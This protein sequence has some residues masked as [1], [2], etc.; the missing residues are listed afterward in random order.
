MTTPAGGYGD[1]A[2]PPQPDLTTLG[3]G[4][5]AM[6]PDQLHEFGGTVAR[7]GDAIGRM[8]AEL[9]DLQHHGMS[10][11]SGEYAPQ[12][13]QFY[14]NLISREAVPAAGVALGEL[15]KMQREVSGSAD[16][17]EQTDQASASQW[18]A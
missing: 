12:I 4:T 7:L 14:R 15:E 11:G 9:L 3:T 6:T 10:V 5:V 2:P 18:R 16:Q 17:W 13:V 1:G 8:Q